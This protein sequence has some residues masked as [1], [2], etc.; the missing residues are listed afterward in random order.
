MG[1]LFQHLEC[2][3]ELFV[4]RTSVIQEQISHIWVD[5]NSITHMNTDTNGFP[6]E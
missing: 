1:R 5:V 2:N 6:A 3:D 4:N